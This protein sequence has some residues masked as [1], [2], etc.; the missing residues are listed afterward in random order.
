MAIILVTGGAG[1]I[2]SHLVETLVGAGHHVRVLDDL[3]SGS[4]RNLR[5]VRQSIDF[6]RADIRDTEMLSSAM[7]GVEGVFHLAAISSVERSVKEPL[8]VQDVNVGGTLCVLEAAR[9]AH[10]RRLVFVSSAAVYGDNP[11]VPLCE[12]EPTQPLSPYGASKVAGEA[13][14]GAYHHLGYLETV[15]LRFFNIFGPRQDPSSPYSGVISIFCRNASQGLFSALDGDG[16]QTRDFL[17]VEDACQ[18]LE[19]AMGE[20]R[21]AGKVI[22]VAGGQETTIRALGETIYRLAGTS[23]QPLARPPRA[24]DI[25]RSLANN[26]LVGDLLDWQPKVPLEDGLRQTLAWMH[27]QR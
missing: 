4:L 10:V 17:Y 5:E 23:F 12:E 3:S 15:V 25:R 16:G 20:E 2:G 7:R 8:H 21:A 1:F 9:R 22:N 27:S 11:R 6:L 19:L 26:R 14:C 13:Y 24:G 18:A